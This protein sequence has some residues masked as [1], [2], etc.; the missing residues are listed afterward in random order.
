[1]FSNRQNV[2]TTIM[3]NFKTPRVKKEIY[4]IL[5]LRQFI[6]NLLGQYSVLLSMTEENRN[7]SSSEDFRLIIKILHQIYA[8]YFLIRT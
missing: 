7:K 5:R 1:M 3:Q 2:F 8:T 4:A 6:E